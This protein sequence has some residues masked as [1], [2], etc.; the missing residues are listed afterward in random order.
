MSTFS[1]G[2]AE[3]R[4]SFGR[5]RVV[6]EKA[7]SQRVF[8]RIGAGEACAADHDIGAVLA[9]IGPKALPEKLHGAAVAIGL[10][11]AGAA[12]LHEMVRGALPGDERRDVIFA[13]S[14]K[15]LVF[16]GDF[17]QQD[18]IS[19]DNLRAP[20]PRPPAH[21]L[22]REVGHQEVIADGIELVLVALFVQGPAVRNRGHLLVEDIEAQALRSFNVGDGAGETHFQV[23]DLAVNP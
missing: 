18:A 4:H 7:Q 23:S 20:G 12:K 14:I 13:L 5:A 3:T 15:P 22:G 16:L 9:N 8:L 1:S 2:W 21:F 11:H 17:L 10:E 19:A 6:M